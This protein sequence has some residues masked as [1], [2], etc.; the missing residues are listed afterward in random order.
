MDELYDEGEEAAEPLGD[1]PAEPGDPLL[2]PGGGEPVGEQ[3]Q[4][5]LQ[6]VRPRHEPGSEG[7]RP[8][9]IPANAV[10]C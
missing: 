6:E 4:R 5:E 9:V 1:R 10:G 7:D 8:E 3:P 2:L